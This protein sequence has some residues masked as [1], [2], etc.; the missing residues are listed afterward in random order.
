MPYFF[1]AT[2]LQE[3]IKYQCQILFQFSIVKASIR[4]SIISET[5]ITTRNY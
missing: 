4:C 2:P 3:N 5:D 1:S